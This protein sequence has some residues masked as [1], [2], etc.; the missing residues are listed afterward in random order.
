MIHLQFMKSS[1][2]RGLGRQFNFG[3]DDGCFVQY[4]PRSFFTAG[5]LSASRNRST[6]P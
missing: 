1:V 6:L 5:P 4:V 2:N 3:F